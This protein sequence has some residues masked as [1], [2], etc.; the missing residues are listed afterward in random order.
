M[1]EA[2]ALKAECEQKKRD[3]FERMRWHEQEK[4]KIEAQEKKQENFR[5]KFENEMKCRQERE[6]EGQLN[7]KFIFYSFILPLACKGRVVFLWLYKPWSL[8]F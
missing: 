8:L 4:R 5:R 1:N 3:E 6:E 7:S 2:A